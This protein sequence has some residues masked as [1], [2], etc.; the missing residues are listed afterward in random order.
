MI[1]MFNRIHEQVRIRTEVCVREMRRGHCFSRCR[2][3]RSLQIVCSKLAISDCINCSKTSS[4]EGVKYI[5]VSSP[6]RGCVYIRM[7]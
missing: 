6:R 4:Q 3:G 1:Q 7:L 2:Y 5:F